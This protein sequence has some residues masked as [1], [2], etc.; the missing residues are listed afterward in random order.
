VYAM[1]FTR[2]CARVD[3]KCT[4]VCALAARLILFT[5]LPRITVAARNVP[6]LSPKSSNRS[7]N[8]EH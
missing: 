6:F 8:I 5:Y 4:R 2:A 1:Y 7:T 3:E